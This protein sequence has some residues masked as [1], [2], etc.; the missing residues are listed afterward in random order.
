VVNLYQ[1]LKLRKEVEQLRLEV[2]DGF[3]ELKQALKDQGAEIK[4]LIEQ[5]AQDVEFKHLAQL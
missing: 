3:I 1:T 2:K 5:V 4:Q